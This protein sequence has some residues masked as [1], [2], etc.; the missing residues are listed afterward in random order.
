MVNKCFLIGRVGGHPEVKHTSTSGKLVAS[1]SLAVDEGTGD[2]KTTF[3]FQLT[4]WDKTAEVVRDHV[5][6]GRLVHVEG[7]L[8]VE[9]WEKDGEKRKAYSITVER[10]SLL[11]KKPE[12]SPSR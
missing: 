11:D 12:P 2:R 5:R 7:R 9:E 4:A 8:R 3:W 1:F 10:V 6:K